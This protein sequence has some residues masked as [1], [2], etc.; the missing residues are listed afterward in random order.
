MAKFL[1]NRGLCPREKFDDGEFRFVAIYSKNREEWT[2]SD[3]GALL[4][5]ITVVT[6]YDTLGED[7]TEY[8]L[9]Q[10][11]IKTCFMSADKIK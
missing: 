7:S 2:I 9:N 11:R 5:G 4:T 6:L 3:F 1:N 8:I 10:T